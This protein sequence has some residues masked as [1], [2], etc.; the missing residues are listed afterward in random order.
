MSKTWKRIVAFGL[1]AVLLAVGILPLFRANAYAT[2]HG[3]GDYKLT[4]SVD[5]NT[6]W[7][8]ALSIGEAEWNSGDEYLSGDGHYVMSAEL[9][10]PNDQVKQVTSIRPGGG[11]GS[12][13]IQQAGNPEDWGETHKK[14][15]YTI[16]YELPEGV[17]INHLSLNPYSEDNG[18][19]PDPGPQGNSVALMHFTSVPGN[20]TEAC[21]DGE[22][23]EETECEVTYA[24]QLQEVSFAINH[25]RMEGIPP[26]ENPAAGYDTEYHYDADDQ[27]ETVVLTLG[28]RWHMMYETEIIINNQSYGIPIDYADQSSWLH[29]YAGQIVS[30]ELEVPRSD[31]YNIVVKVRRNPVMHIGNFLWTADPAHEWE[32]MRDE[33]GRDIVDEDGNYVYIEDEEGNLIPNHAYIGHSTLALVAVSYELNG[34][35]Y[36]CN[37]DEGICTVRDGDNE[38]TCSIVDDEDCGIP[39]VEFSSEGE[40]DDNGSLVVPAGARVTMRAIPNYGYQ[41]VDINVAELTTT[42][43]GVGEFS[44]TIPAG[45][46][47]FTANVTKIDDTVNAESNK[48]AGGAIDLGDGQS[49]LTHGTARLDVKDVD[50]TDEDVAGFEG[51]AEGYNVKSYLD[52]SLFNVIYRGSTD[53]AWENQVDDLNEPATITLQLEEGVDGNEVVIVHQKHDGTYEVIP[54]VYDPVANTLTFTTSSFSNYAI[55]SRT[56]EETSDTSTASPETGRMINSETLASENYIAIAVAVLCVAVAFGMYKIFD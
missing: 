28:T 21:I 6:D 3:E 29:H 43:D 56:V 2:S 50:L 15:T 55:A 22:S 42:D 37:A 27:D 25:G 8:A 13:V 10:V 45:A 41:V 16:N 34:V 11:S 31:N 24:E 12:F 5:S 23:H 35:S 40:G 26:T 51:A 19:N 36:Y 18:G 1:S 9:H 52:I 48:V 47:Y 4:L 53:E 49:T 7:L 14:F 44:F 33:E 39:Y 54:A 46:A 30:F 38:D 32:V 20:Y 17:Q